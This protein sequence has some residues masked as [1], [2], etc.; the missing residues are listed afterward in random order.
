MQTSSRDGM[1]EKSTE[2]L[3]KQFW[4]IQRVKNLA[5]IQKLS[6][7]QK[8]KIKLGEKKN[9]ASEPKK[10]GEIRKEEKGGAGR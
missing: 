1:A 9:T 6:D 4:D 10:Q 7:Y 8:I 5:K 3:Q 2:K